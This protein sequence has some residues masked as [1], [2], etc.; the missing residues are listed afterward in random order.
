MKFRH[1]EQALEKYAEDFERSLIQKLPS[2]F[3]IIK[4]IETRVEVLGNNYRVVLRLA[5]YWKWIE[6]GREPGKQP[7]SNKLIE[8][9]R[10]RGITP[11][12]GITSEKSLAFLIGR[13]VAREGI[14]PRRYLAQTQEEFKDFRSK[15]IEAFKY[16]VREFT[17][18]IMMELKN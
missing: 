9:I 5:D 3:G 18:G 12:N 17:E 10:R 4:T 11:R 16:D 14:K 2:E 8:W 7:P 13:K 15:I 6:E 1:L